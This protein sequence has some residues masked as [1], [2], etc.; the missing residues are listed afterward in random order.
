MNARRLKQLSITEREEIVAYMV[1]GG[2]ANEVY[3]RYRLSFHQIKKLLYDR[4][5]AL[6][7][8]ERSYATSN[9]SL[10]WRKS[11]NPL[12][13]TPL[14]EELIAK[15]KEGFD[16][17]DLAQHFKTSPTAIQKIKSEL[18]L[19]PPKTRL[20][21]HSTKKE[22]RHQYVFRSTP[23]Q[24]SSTQPSQ[25]EIPFDSSE[26]EVMDIKEKDQQ[27]VITNFIAIIKHNELSNQHIKSNKFQSLKEWLETTLGQKYTWR[28]LAK[29]LIYS[30]KLFRIILD[31][32]IYLFQLE[33]CDPDQNIA[34]FRLEHILS[35]T[36]IGPTMTK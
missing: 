12:I 33:G 3:K 15:V 13:L 2:Y 23:S 21:G 6:S 22:D 36:P 35:E 7:Y 9:N 11:I 14:G 31:D 16:E 10:R 26:K 29:G 30:H 1:N 4:G 18:G 32:V 20:K 27:S 5:M 25:T 8:R 17:E 34:I 24:T 28:Q 19:V